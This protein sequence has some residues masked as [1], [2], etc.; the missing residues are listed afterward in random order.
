MTLIEQ[1][2]KLSEDILRND[3]TVTEYEENLAKKES[4]LKNLIIDSETSEYLKHPFKLMRTSLEKERLRQ[5]KE[6]YF[7][8]RNSSLTDI[9]NISETDE[10][11]EALENAAKDVKPRKIKKFI[12]SH[13]LNDIPDS[14]KLLKTRK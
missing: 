12:E 11:G 9:I 13:S 8:I 14:K 7:K 5:I 4:Y 2:T 1:Y 10:F 3:E 6:A